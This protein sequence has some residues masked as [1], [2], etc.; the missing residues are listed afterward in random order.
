MDNNQLSLGFAPLINNRKYVIFRA[1]DMRKPLCESLVPRKSNVGAV[2]ITNR[3]F[4]LFEVP[5]TILEV[6]KEYGTIT[7][8]TRKM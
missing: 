3:M 6:Y 5:Y 4:S 8:C 2:K 7:W 1:P